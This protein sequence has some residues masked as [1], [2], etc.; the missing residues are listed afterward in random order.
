M[1]IK[2]EEQTSSNVQPQTTEQTNA[3]ETT[4]VKEA[5]TDK[6]EEST[7]K[8]E[9]SKGKSKLALKR[10]DESFVYDVMQVPTA[11]HHEY[12]MV[13]FIIIWAKRNNINYEMDDYGNLYLT[14]G[15][16]D[17]GES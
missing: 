14:K 15:V 4:S 5:S 16:L 10:L 17:E 1:D 3:A 11:T 8:T 9:D 13:M 7:E 6:K 12:R 2:K